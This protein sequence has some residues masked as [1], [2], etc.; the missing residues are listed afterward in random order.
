MLAPSAG[1]DIANAGDV[2]VS[3]HL[4]VFTPSF[5]IAGMST[6]G[7]ASAT[8]SDRRAGQHPAVEPLV[9]TG[10]RAGEPARLVGSVFH[11]SRSRVGASRR[12]QC[13]QRW[14]R[15]RATVPRS[16]WAISNCCGRSRRDEQLSGR[17]V[18]RGRAFERAGRD[19]VLVQHRIRVDGRS[20][21]R[22]QRDPERD[23]RLRW[24]RERDQR[25][26]VTPG[27]HDHHATRPADADD[28][29]D[30]GPARSGGRVVALVQSGAARIG[31]AADPTPP[32][33]A[34][35][36]R[37]DTHHRDRHPDEQRRA[38]ARPERLPAGASS[39][40]VGLAQG[41][42]PIG[43]PQGGAQEEGPA[44]HAQEEA[45]EGAGDPQGR[46]QERGEARGRQEGGRERE[47]EEGA[48]RAPASSRSCRPRS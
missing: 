27:H 34:D 19:L 7:S 20:E 26:A 38:A 11:L 13:L 2:S 40:E 31:A 43:A 8:V 10:R 18:P 29:S 39:S 44:H 23:L 47:G 16:S 33:P 28:R 5:T 21:L 41:P 46:A 37:S 14:S 3:M 15:S 12:D 32:A 9:P 22:D 35:D 30:E 42:S 1:A 4:S 25:R 17:A 6:T 48:R 24:K 36:G 45:G